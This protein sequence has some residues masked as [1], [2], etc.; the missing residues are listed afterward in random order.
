ME[1]RSK[2]AVLVAEDTRSARE[3]LAAYLAKQGHEAVFAEN[4]EQAVAQFRER[5]PDVVLMDVMMPVMDGYEATR[6]IKAIAGDH[7]VPVVF[8]S[9]LCRDEDLVRGLEAG[10]DDYLFKPVNLHV[11][12]AKLNSLRRAIELQRGLE[13]SRRRLQ[14]VSDCLIDSIITIDRDAVIQSVNPAAENMFGYAAAEMVGRNVS[15]LMPEPFRS[16]HDGYV[17]RYV[18]GG[19][20]HIVGVGGREVRCQRKDGSL[21]DAEVGVTEARF[22]GRRIFIGVVRDVSERKRAVE[23]LAEYAEQLR[24]LHEAAEEE[25]RLAREII[26]RQ[27]FGRQRRDPRLASWILPAHHFSGDVVSVARG[28]DGRLYAMLADAT[29]HG[30]AAAISVMQGF[31]L[32]NVLAA[33]GMPLDELA[34]ELNRRIRESLPVGRFVAAVLLALDEAKGRG[35]IWVGG[36]PEVLRLDGEGRIVQRFASLH[37]PL[38]VAGEGEPSWRTEAFEWHE[39]GQIV[40]CSDGLLEAENADGEPFGSARLADALRAPSRLEAVRAA[41]E[42]HLSGTPT[43]DDISV[44]LVDLASRAA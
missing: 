24:G 26:E 28:P 3:M 35:E 4:G 6:R 18:N 32:F 44:A 15:M 14:L 21:F 22:E 10:G 12:S 11:L 42:T 31:N 37:L 30:L 38:G 13:E 5:R 17:S 33:G 7:W 16:A 9:A 40:A 1:N 19:R 27:V 8:L 43:R 23:K 25:S 34:H 20:P 41:V 36:M 29:G 39:P 2:L